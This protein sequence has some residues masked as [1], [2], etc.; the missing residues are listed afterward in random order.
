MVFKEDFFTFFPKNVAKFRDVVSTDV[1][2]FLVVTNFVESGHS[3]GREC[4]RLILRKPNSNLFLA[5]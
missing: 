4:E 2:K 5:A 1:P 3:S